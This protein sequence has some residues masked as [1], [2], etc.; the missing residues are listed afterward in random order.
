MRSIHGAAM[1]E[2]LTDLRSDALREIGNIGAG[3]AADALSRL[4]NATILTSHPRASVMQFRALPEELGHGSRPIAALH[5]FV[6]GALPGQMIVLFDR[7]YSR[8]FVSDFVQNSLGDIADLD[9]IVDS[10]LKEMANIVAGAYLNALARMTSDGK[11]LPSVPMLS[12][13]ASADALSAFASTLPD[14]EVIVLESRFTD[15]ASEI[16][17]QIVFIPEIEALAPMLAAFGIA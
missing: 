11:L 8:R 9:A 1:L 3:H 12:F 2:A 17:G 6:R 13:G 10:T 15:T 16:S 4:L 14:Q 7:E 5:V